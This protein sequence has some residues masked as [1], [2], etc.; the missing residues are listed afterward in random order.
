MP[1]EYDSTLAPILDR[2]SVFGVR[3]GDSPLCT[4]KKP[5]RPWVTFEGASLSLTQTN[6]LVYRPL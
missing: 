3:V 5:L 2:T 6:L 4:L 1:K